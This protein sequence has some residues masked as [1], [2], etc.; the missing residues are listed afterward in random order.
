MRVYDGCL[1]YIRAAAAVRARVYSAEL[2]RRSVG[3]ATTLLAPSYPSQPHLVLAMPLPPEEWWAT[4][5]TVYAS[6]LGLAQCHWHLG[7]I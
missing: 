4:D 2:G 5:D 7:E 6:E 3:F 1:L